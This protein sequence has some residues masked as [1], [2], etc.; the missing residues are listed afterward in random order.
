M[1]GRCIKCGKVVPE[2]NSS[3]LCQDCLREDVRRFF[4]EHPDLKKT[5]QGSIEEMRKPENV[6]KMVDDTCRFMKA[7]KRMQRWSE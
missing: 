6:K 5:F 2:K 3:D 7:I 4:N 1:E